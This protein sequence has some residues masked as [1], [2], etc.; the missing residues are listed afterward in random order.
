M[1]PP[2]VAV[3]LVEGDPST[4]ETRYVHDVYEQIASHFSATRYKPWPIIS[5]FL[6]ELPTG[7]VGLDS[8]TGNG[9]YLPLPAERPGA[10]WTVGLDRSLSLLETAK[11]A[12]GVTREVVWGDVLG[13]G[14]RR[15]AFDYAV[16]IATIHHLATPER[17]RLAVRRLLESVSSTHGRVLIYVWATEQDALSKRSIPSSRTDICVTE[18]QDVFVPWVLSPSMPP[19]P[20]KSRRQEGHQSKPAVGPDTSPVPARQKFSRYYHMFSEG[21]LRRLVEYV[22]NDLCLPIGRK[23][24]HPVGTSGVEIVQSG[25]ERSN[26]YIE[27]RRWG[28]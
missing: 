7:W 18:G 25:W 24:D 17:R 21:E 12:G 27:L 22:A 10:V 19:Q 20:R 26:Y 1:S 14:W 28:L 8:G 13:K 3:A 23:E 6:S 4:Y 9:K 16:S 15:G 5:H 11:M 2:R